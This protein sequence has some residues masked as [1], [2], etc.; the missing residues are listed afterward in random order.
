MTMTQPSISGPGQ[1][2]VDYLRQDP[3]RLIQ[4][5]GYSCQ[6]HVALEVTRAVFGGLSQR[7]WFSRDFNPV[8]NVDSSNP[9]QIYLALSRAVQTGD[10]GGKTIRGYTAALLGIADKHPTAKAALR[11]QIKAAPIDWFR[12]QIW[13][14][15]LDS[16]AANRK[17]DVTGL[18]GECQQN[19]RDAVNRSPGQVLQPD[20]YLLKDLTPAE[21]AIIVDG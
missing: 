15:D 10:V 13:L 1:C 14:L 7:V 17:T 4:Q 11:Q 8:N 6:A 12:P 19:A 5:F 16:L 18:L 20:E 9:A 21:Y 3:P 2:Q